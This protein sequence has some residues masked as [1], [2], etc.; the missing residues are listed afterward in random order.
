MRVSSPSFRRVA[1]L[2]LLIAAVAGCS[3]DKNPTSPGAIA[4]QDAADDLALQTVA[5]LSVTA[6]D[7]QAA[8]ATVPQEAA[9]PARTATP[10]QAQWDTAYTQGGLTFIATRTFFDADGS[11]LPDYGPTAARMTWTSHIYGTVEYPRDTASVEHR[12]TIDVRGIQPAQDTLRFDGGVF[13]T[14]VNRFRSYDGTRTR[15]GAWRSYFTLENVRILKSALAAGL[16]YPIAG[17]CTFAVSLDRLRSNDIADV[18]SH[19]DA[20]V[21]VTFNGTTVVDVVVDGTYRYRWNLVN[22]QV[23][24]A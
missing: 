10:T 19:V 8:V 1:A 24:R 7:L 6:A 18:A 13:D 4:S 2:L 17:R 21:L 22:G 3:K 14:L 23:T 16:G 15:Y 20:T 5:S 11:I 12:A 9:A